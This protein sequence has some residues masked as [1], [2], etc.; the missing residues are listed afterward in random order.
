M[1]EDVTKKI[2]SMNPPAKSLHPTIINNRFAFLDI[3]RFCG[4]L[5]VAFAHIANSYIVE[6][7]PIFIGGGS[8]VIIFFLISGYIMPHAILRSRNIKNFLVKRCIRLFPL[9]ILTAIYGLIRYSESEIKI[10]NIIT[11]NSCDKIDGCD[12]EYYDVND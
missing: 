4:A 6:N 9:L 12:V 1:K 7:F 5:I 3:L 11:L 10:E 8:G 2:T